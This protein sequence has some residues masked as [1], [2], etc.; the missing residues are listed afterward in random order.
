MSRISIGA[1]NAN[2]EFVPAEFPAPRAK[3]GKGLLSWCIYQMVA[4]GQ[5]MSRI[6]ADFAKLLGLE[7]AIAS[8]YR[9]REA[10]SI[11]YRHLSSVIFRN[12]MSSSGNYP[13]C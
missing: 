7:I 6:L 2:G 13:R 1:A 10:I 5:N 3:F 12:I 11:S 4:G 9:F 8:A